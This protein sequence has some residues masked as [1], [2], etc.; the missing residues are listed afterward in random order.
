MLN[1][2]FTKCCISLTENILNQGLSTVSSLSLSLPRSLSICKAN[3]K[4]SEL[5]CILAA[6]SQVKVAGRVKQSKG[7]AEIKVC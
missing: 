4:F 3:S 2:Y 6:S 5:I 1:M 7:K